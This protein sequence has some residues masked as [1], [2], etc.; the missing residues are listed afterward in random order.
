MLFD[1]ATSALDAENE[2]AVVDA[3]H[4]LSRDRTVLVIAHRLSTIAAADQIA[5]LEDGRITQLG[6]HEELLAQEGRYRSFW[7]DREKAQGWRISRS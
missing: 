5:M 7:A 3:M 1:E 4:E 2:A 6:T